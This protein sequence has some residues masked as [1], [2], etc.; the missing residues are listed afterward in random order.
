MRETSFHVRVEL[1][2]RAES[3]AF[4]NSPRWTRVEASLAKLEMLLN[5]SLAA[6]YIFSS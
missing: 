2:L 3:T 4:W 5:R 6:S 1:A